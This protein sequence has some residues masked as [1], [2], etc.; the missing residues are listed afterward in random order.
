MV[1]PLEGNQKEGMEGKR[2]TKQKVNK[3]K[4]LSPDDDYIGNTKKAKGTSTALE[5]FSDFYTFF[6]LRPK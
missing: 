6:I 3:I 5:H 1:R 4:P 2:P